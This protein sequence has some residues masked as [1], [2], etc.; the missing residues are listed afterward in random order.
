MPWLN[1]AIKDALEKGHG[2]AVGK[3][4]TCEAETMYLFHHKH[5]YNW[6]TQTAMTRN[7]GLWPASNATLH[8][9]ATHMSK[10]VLPHM[11]AVAAWY[12]P[13][14]E[15]VVLKAYA[16]TARIESGLDWLNPWHDLWTTVIPSDVKVAVVCPF[17][18]SIVHQTPHLNHLFPQPIWPTPLPQIIPIK[19]GCSP[20]YDSTSPA[21]W[22]DHI[23]KGGWRI[24]VVDIVRSVVSSGARVALVGCGALSLPIVVA[25]KARG[26]VA[27]HT[28]GSTQCIFGIRGKRWITDREIA[29]L[30]HSPLW[31]NPRPSETPTHATTIEG[32]CYWMPHSPS[33]YTPPS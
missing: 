33:E 5:P 21:A 10:H 30:L 3:L 22:P 18:E 29:P 16:P 4:G 23:Q 15:N 7:A 28:G 12:N 8:E 25:L 26:I 1:H 11:D 32:G 31:T 20:V 2:L 19:T 13:E 24:A 27:I 14:H 6:I 17:A 9:W